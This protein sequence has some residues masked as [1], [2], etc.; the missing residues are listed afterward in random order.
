MKHVTKDGG[1]GLATD[2]IGIAIAVIAAWA[3]ST[4]ASV[5]M[6]VEVQTA[7]G[8]V[9]LGITHRVDNYLQM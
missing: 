3:L 7:L 9:I 2:G 1:R 8:A 5:D 4:F 6:S